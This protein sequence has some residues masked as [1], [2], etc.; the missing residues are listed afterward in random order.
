MILFVQR[1]YRG[2]TLLLVRCYLIESTSFDFEPL[3][4][5]LS[6]TQYITHSRPPRTLSKIGGFVA[7]VLK[8]SHSHSLFTFSLVIFSLVAACIWVKVAVCTS[9]YQH[10]FVDKL[11]SPNDYFWAKFTTCEPC[12]AVLLEKQSH[13]DYCGSFWALIWFVE[14]ISLVNLPIPVSFFDKLP[15]IL[16]NWAHFFLGS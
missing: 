10:A 15:N 13:C 6:I 16:T 12:A 11:S 5:N 9:G 14:S 8:L 4:K 2:R 3:Q 7:F 1:W